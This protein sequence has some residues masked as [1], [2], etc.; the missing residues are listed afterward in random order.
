MLY[1]QFISISKILNEELISNFDYWLATLP[2]RSKKGLTL[3]MIA[4]KFG[5]DT[6]IAEVIIDYCIKQGIFE[7]E[8]LIR[9]DN[10]E[11]EMPLEHITLDQIADK[12]NSVV[13]CN[14][15]DQEFRISFDNIYKTYKVIKN[16]EASKEEIKKEILKRL[17]TE[18]NGH[19]ENFSRADSL[20]NDKFKIYEAYYNPDE[21]AYDEMTQLFESLDNDYGKNTT[22]KGEV[23][24]ELALKIVTS[25]KHVSG[26]TKLTS[27]T[28]QFDCVVQQPI[29]TSY[30]SL[31]NFMTPYFIIECKNEASSPG[32]TYFHKLSSIMDKNEA[33]LGFVFSRKAAGKPALQ[34][35]RETYLSKLSGPKPQ[36]LINLYNKDLGMIV[37]ERENFLRVVDFKMMELTLNARNANYEWFVESKGT[38]VERQNDV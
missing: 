18:S 2:N 27:Y 24:E 23:L 13:T 6:S 7:E 33:K 36:Y 1:K 37:K 32:T 21:S 3:S 8:Y 20:A 12:V 5:I 9:C 28:N 38:S 25:I 15:C 14:R 29:S 22:K 30:P 16:P 19:Q 11:C 17:G 34:T 26:T 31:M 35:A 4:S 10:D